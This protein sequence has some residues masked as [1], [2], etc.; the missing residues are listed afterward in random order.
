MGMFD[1][2]KCRYP[3]P[4]EG[5]NDL[6]FQTKSLYKRLDDFEIREDGTLWKKPDNETEWYKFNFTG[7]IR[8]HAIWNEE[9]IN[10]EA[11]YSGWIDF[12]AYFI[13]GAIQSVSVIQNK[14]ASSN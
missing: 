2:L 7:E 12:S 5:A 11:K 14:P 4:V 13:D 10:E 6:D 3:L 1:Y 8:F 9:F